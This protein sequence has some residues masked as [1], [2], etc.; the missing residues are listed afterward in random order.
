[1]ALAPFFSPGII[2]NLE[3]NPDKEAYFKALQIQLFKHI[4]KYIRETNLN[5]DTNNLLIKIVDMESALFRDK[6]YQA[7]DNKN[8]DVIIQ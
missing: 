1:M 5:V 4:K 2:K 7:I 3:T 8:E 6:I